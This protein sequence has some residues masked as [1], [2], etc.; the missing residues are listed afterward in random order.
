MS[1]SDFDSMIAALT[2]NAVTPAR[3]DAAA[4][5]LTMLSAL[6]DEVRDR[7]MSL[8]PRGADGWRSTAADRYV[9]RLDE[10]RQILEAVVDSLASAESQLADRISGMRS[11]LEAQEAAARAEADRADALRES[12]ARADEARAER[13]SESSESSQGSESSEGSEGSV[14]GAAAGGGTAWTTR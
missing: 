2:G 13:G 1:D 7:R 9:E 10:L 4:R 11:E 8:V 6:H 12:L 14:G 3:I 5:H